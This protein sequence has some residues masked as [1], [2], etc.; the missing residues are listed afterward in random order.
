MCAVCAPA[1]EEI[2]LF[3]FNNATGGGIGPN[4]LT[5]DAKG[6]LYGTT[7]DGL[8]FEVSPP[9]AAGGPWTE[10][11]LYQ[12]TGGS[13]GGHPTSGLLID[14]AGNLYGTAQVG[15]QSATYECYLA[16]CGVVFEL[17]PPTQPGGGWTETT[18]YAFPGS[19]DGNIPWA[20]LIFDDAGNL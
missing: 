2:L 14:S 3:G 19:P 5:A 9:K 17:S 20:G 16:A 1:A 13:D 12:F 6:N 10:T 4:G 15:G 7:S 18:L 11:V 8:A